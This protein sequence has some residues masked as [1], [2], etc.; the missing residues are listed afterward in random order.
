MGVL[1]VVPQLDLFILCLIGGGAG[2]VCSISILFTMLCHVSNRKSMEREL[3][4]GKHSS[5]G[6]DLRLD[7]G[8]GRGHGEMKKYRRWTE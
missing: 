2:V 8:R 7:F 1:R 6:L 4:R 5:E 3:P